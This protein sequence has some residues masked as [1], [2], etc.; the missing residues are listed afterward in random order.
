MV[1]SR[2]DTETVHILPITWMPIPQ[3]WQPS[4]VEG[5]IKVSSPDPSHPS[6][7]RMWTVVLIKISTDD[8]GE[9]AILYKRKLMSVFQPSLQK[10][11]T[12]TLVDKVE[13]LMRVPAINAENTPS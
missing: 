1:E 10:V 9:T 8:E 12:A 13:T 3:S 5:K 4:F 2:Q 7:F 11:S 6:G